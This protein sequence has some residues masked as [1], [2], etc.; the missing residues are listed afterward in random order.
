MPVGFVAF[1]YPRPEYVEEFTDRVHKAAEFLRPR[2][3]CLS[4]EC[5]ATTDGEA[6]VTTGR[7][8]SEEALQAAFAGAL[9]SGVIVDADEREVRPRQFFTLLAR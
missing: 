9:E 7:F 8:E 3:G 1:H 5:W 4:V 2:P 6:I